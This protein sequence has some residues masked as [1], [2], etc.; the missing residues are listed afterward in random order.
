M[1]KPGDSRAQAARV[2]ELVL[3]EG[4]TLE[5]ALALVAPGP[6]QRATV[7][8]LAYGTIRWDPELEV[9]L[10]LMLSR[11]LASLDPSLRALLL[12][13]L[14]QLMHGETPEHAAVA[15]TV[16][17]ARLIGQAR[18]AGL[19]NAILRRFLRERAAL[20]ETARRNDAAV[21]AHPHWLIEALR[22]DWPKQW[23]AVL[24]A[25]NEHPPMW[26]RVNLRR[27]SV[28]D[29]RARL[30][31]AGFEAE[32]APFAPAALRLAQPVDVTRLP[33][34]EAGDASVQDLAAQLVAP[35]LDVKPGMRVL[36]ACAAP[37]GKACQLLETVPGLASLTALELDPTR[38]KRIHD[39]LGRLGLAADVVVGDATEPSSWWDGRP[40][41]RILVDAPCSGTGVIRRHP[42]IKAL[43]RPADI[44]ALVGTQRRLLAA[45]WPLLAPGGRLVYASCSVLR[46]ENSGVIAAFL[47]DTTDA[48][49][50]G[51]SARLIV[52]GAL[53]APGPG[54]GP[55]HAILTGMAGA[56]GFYYAC[57]DKRA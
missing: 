31:E 7:Q 54:P 29:Y 4:R 38:A 21:Y 15:E 28:E 9:V 50:S 5:S 52:Q 53:G 27:C 12:V 22:R 16:E 42:D 48:V 57:L 17:A 24:A 3:A 18:A 10:P 45:L 2:V 14:Y 33:G 13:G 40:Y 36:D 39:N 35:M 8:S 49:E 47:A 1:H 43:R 56:D 32:R 46:A 11:P 37:G 51:E 34:F 41:D 19:V 25:G 20:L 23:K 26:L 30:A 44:P 55:G 6:A